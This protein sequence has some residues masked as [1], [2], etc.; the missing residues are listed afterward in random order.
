MTKPYDRPSQPRLRIKSHQANKFI[1]S[2][3]KSS[4]KKTPVSSIWAVF[5]A[6]H[7]KSHLKPIRKFQALPRQNRHS[8]R[9]KNQKSHQAER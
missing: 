2:T 4:L 6:H 9:V 1:P 5:Q 8:E 3:T 7:K